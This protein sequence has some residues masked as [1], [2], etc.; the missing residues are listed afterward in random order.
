MAYHTSL[1]NSQEFTA[2]LL[3]ARELAHNIT[4]GMRKI[5]GTSPDFEV[6][7]YTYVH[8]FPRLLL[9]SHWCWP[10]FL[11]ITCLPSFFQVDLCILWAVPHYCD[12]GTYQHLYMSAADF[13]GVL[14]AAGI[15]P[16]LRPAQPAH[17]NHDRGGYCWRHDTVGHRLQRSVA[18]QSGHGEN[19]E[20]WFY[21]LFP[22]YA[23]VIV[24]CL[25]FVSFLQSFSL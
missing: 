3:K 1:T 24:C 20:L 9:L 25:A 8:I 17:H 21:F 4:L 7:P 22:P 23:Y 11:N 14:S 10:E 6:F 15:G 12:G 13:R 2:A 5:N 18:Y 19:K 16:A